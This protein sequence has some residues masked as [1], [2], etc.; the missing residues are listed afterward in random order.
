[1]NRQSLTRAGHPGP[2][3][4]RWRRVYDDFPVAL[5]PVAS[6]SRRKVIKGVALDFDQ[7]GVRFRSDRPLREGEAVNIAFTLPRSAS[8]SFRGLPCRWPGKVRIVRPMEGEEPCYDV[9][10]QWPLPLPD[11]VQGAVNSHR[12]K[13]LAWLFLVLALIIWM[14]W[15]NLKF[16]W[17]TP[18]VYI[19][20]FTIGAYFL[21]RFL[22]SKFYQA[23]PMTGY[24]PT[25]SIVIS[26]RNEEDAIAKTVDSCFDADYPDHK[27]EVIVVDDG[28]ADQ[29]PR[30]LKD[31]QARY[32]GLKVFTIP[33][34]GKRVGMATGVRNAEG[35]I[36]VFVDS[37]TFIYRNALRQIV[38]GFEAPSLGAVSGHTEVENPDKNALTGLQEV[39]YFLSYRLMKASESVFGCVSCCPG[40]LS[41]YRR[42]Y[43]L[44]VL[45]AWLAQ[46][47]LGATA[48]FGDDR[49]LTNYILRNYRVIYNERVLSTTMVPETWPRYLRQQVRWKKSWLRETMIAARF[50]YK[51]HPAAAISFYL[52][53][54]CSLLSPIAVFRALYIGFMDPGG[55]M[56]LFYFV[57]L[58]LDGLSQCLF[59][60]AARPNSHWMLGMLL[61]AS[62]L[63]V[64]G[65]QTYYAIL[66]M[67]KNHWGTR[68]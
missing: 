16:F 15:D 19:Y 50:M 44:D 26:V 4:R 43:V 36:I 41:A 49:S 22:I 12:Q 32:P 11:M 25:L 66:T 30:V 35:E 24:E 21:S 45:D 63:I 58:V 20:S 57:G 40:C 60:L 29:T 55:M 64:L 67:R 1:M 37:D 48:T 3:R 39:R 27:R 59:Y 9:V 31:L 7:E 46:T 65:P 38:C 68:S 6:G 34:S 13:I 28:S 47:F 18:W 8:N 52:S 5:T 2:E 51:K 56:L 42:S 23:P 62:Q 17:Y 10:L 54:I 14:K 33:P 53:A 61:V